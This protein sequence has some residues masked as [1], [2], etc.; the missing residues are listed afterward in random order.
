[1]TINRSKAY[2]RIHDETWEQY[3]PSDGAI[4]ASEEHWL[5][6]YAPK[7]R[8]R[9]GMPRLIAEGALSEVSGLLRS[10]NPSLFRS[11]EDLLARFYRLRDEVTEFSSD[12]SRENWRRYEQKGDSDD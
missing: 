7:W 11:D 6:V 3:K 8:N 1:M 9:V 12:F 2:D 5:K 4:R 10:I